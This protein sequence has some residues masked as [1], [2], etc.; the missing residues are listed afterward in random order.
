[1]RKLINL[2]K[3]IITEIEKRYNITLLKDESEDINSDL[4]SYKCNICGAEYKKNLSELRRTRQ[5]IPCVSCAKHEYFEHRLKNKYKFNTLT[6]NK[7]KFITNNTDFIEVT[8][9]R[10][11]TTFNTTYDLLLRG[12]G[13]EAPCKYCLDKRLSKK[14][15]ETI[16]AYTV[17]EI[18][19]MLNSIGGDYEFKSDVNRRYTS[20]DEINLKCKKCDYEF[21]TTIQEL[22]LSV[23]KG[24]RK[25]PRCNKKERVSD[26]DVVKYIEA[27][28][29][30]K[31]LEFK[32][33][34]EHIKC[35]C[36]K[37]GKITDRYYQ[38][39]FTSDC[40]YC[41]GNG[42]SNP[43]TEILEY[44]TS[45]DANMKIISHDRSV[46]RGVYELDFY[47]PEK[48]FAIEYDGLYYHSSDKKDSKYHLSKTKAC[49]DKGIRLIHI[50]EDEW[51]F[52][53]EIV[54]TKL[55]HI[56][57]YDTDDRIYARQC[58]VSIV[59]NTQEARSI[60]AENHIQGFSN[61]LIRYGLYFK[62]ELVA[63][64]TFGNYRKNMGRTAV[65]NEYELLRYATTKN[66]VGGF[67]KLLKHFIK[68]VNP[69]KIITYADLRWTAY[70][71]L[72]SNVYETNGFKMV[73][74]SAPNYFYCKDQHR[75]SRY[76]FR[77]SELKNLFPDIFDE[78]LSEFQIMNKTNYTR[79]FD[80]GNIL[81]EYSKEDNN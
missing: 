18:I 73:H 27:N 8:C 62:D 23:Q 53:K 13:D 28:R 39:I 5:I 64:M 32:T 52:K 80:C 33:K 15:D 34:H 10:C 76:M 31:V 48:K 75:Y 19:G 74:M 44:L 66:V 7:L 12:R 45:L 14:Y 46:L 55:K 20:G 40:K 43:E 61:S 77:K 42:S 1:M 57:G 71:G 69:N 3:A 59:K 70:P 47:V 65:E 17:D 35:Q 29:P 2:D 9:S 63:I 41:S 6:I 26:L 56:L 81:F 79:I 67:S 49:A 54:K 4:V 38:N 51:L 16:K 50:F 68:D 30:I 24:I 11:G 22:L 25:C 60:L 58:K 36:L 21:K 78:N 72:G 37:C